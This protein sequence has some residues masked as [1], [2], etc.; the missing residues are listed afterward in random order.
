M[1]PTPEEQVLIKRRCAK[2]ILDLVP[3]IVA[4]RFFAVTAAAAGSSRQ[5]QRGGGRHVLAEVEK[6]TEKVDQKS[7]D[8]VSESKSTEEKVGVEAE[9]EEE[10]MILEIEAIL[11]VFGDPYMNKHMVF[12]IVE[13]LLLR[14]VPELGVKSAGELMK[15]R[16]G[17]VDGEKMEDSR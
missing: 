11:D 3:R 1:I 6:E 14:L 15:E 4:R 8:K 7:S 9:E 2:A 17:D 10:E 16:L 12:G 5:D 13:L